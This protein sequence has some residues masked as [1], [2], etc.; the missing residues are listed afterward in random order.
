MKSF[1]C[2]LCAYRLRAAYVRFLNLYPY[3][4]IPHYILHPQPEDLSCQLD[5]VIPSS[6]SDGIATPLPDAWIESH[7]S[8]PG[9]L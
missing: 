3:T 9:P 1:D 5:F 6:T 7:R 4:I 2:F 8:L